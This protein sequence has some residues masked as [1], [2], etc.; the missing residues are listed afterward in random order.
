L[1]TLVIIYDCNILI[2]A[3]D[4]SKSR[5]PWRVQYNENLVP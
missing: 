5:V 2:Q 1:T 3:T 4:V